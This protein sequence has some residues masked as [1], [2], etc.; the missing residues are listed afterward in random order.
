MEE[1]NIKNTAIHEA[2]H[3]VAHVRIDVLKDQKTIDPGEGIL[4]S[5]IAEG[6]NHVWNAKDAAKQVYCYCAGCAALMAIGY[7]AEVACLGAGDDFENASD[8]LEMWD[9]PGTLDEWLNR[10]AE[11]MSEPEN[12]RAVEFVA[13]ALMEYKTLDGDYIEML[14]EWADGN[15]TDEE[16]H[17]FVSFHYPGM[18]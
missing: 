11:F 13:N 6:K 16:W 8:L 7:S 12:I 10:S 17:Q 4:G 5:S 9:L 15:M 14:V 1:S 18:V 2:G 3:A